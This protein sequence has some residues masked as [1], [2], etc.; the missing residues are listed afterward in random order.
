MAIDKTGKVLIN[1]N[2]KNGQY[3]IGSGELK[4][5][6]YLDSLSL[7]RNVNTTSIYGDGEEQE[8]LVSDSSVSGSLGMTAPDE[9]F[10]KDLGYIEDLADGQGS[11]LIKSLPPVNIYCEV[12]FQEKGS[13]AKVKKLWLLNARVTPPGETFSQNTD[14]V[15]PNNSEYPLTV[16]GVNKKASG[17][18][19]DYIDPTTGDTVKQWKVSSKPTDSGYAT[20]GAS[21]PVPTQAGGGD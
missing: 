9:Q 4:P 17:G 15:N 2:V 8:L 20:F 19:S 1:Y 3:Q 18:A 10:E 16:L 7:T 12:Y 13:P 6:T 14:S 11:K 5:L 21:V